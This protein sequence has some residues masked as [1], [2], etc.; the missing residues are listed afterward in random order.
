MCQS[1]PWPQ[2]F[3]GNPDPSDDLCQILFTLNFGICSGSTT[4]RYFIHNQMD[5][6]RVFLQFCCQNESGIKPTKCETF[7]RWCWVEHSTDFN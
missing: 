3:N 7:Y 2:W 4:D 5:F 1:E 6:L